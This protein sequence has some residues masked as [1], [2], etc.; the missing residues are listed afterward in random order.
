VSERARLVE[1]A[2]A[3]RSVIDQ[4]RAAGTRSIRRG[5][6]LGAATCVVTAI[7]MY[8]GGRA[9]PPAAAVL[10]ATAIGVGLGI[11]VTKIVFGARRLVLAYR[12]ARMVEASR[13]PVAQLRG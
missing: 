5:I 6:Q 1:L 11:A 7:V 13:I 9:V 12:V 2:R 4:T 8:V 10:L 3:D